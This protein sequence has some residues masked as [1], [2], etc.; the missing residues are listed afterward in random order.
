MFLGHFAIGLGAK[1]IAPAVSLGTLFLAVQF[2]D[3]L[4]PVFVMLGF[5]SFVIQPGI[6]AFTPLDFVHYPY[7]HSLLMSLLWG[8]AFAIVYFFAGRGRKQAAGMLAL[9]VLSHWLLDVASHR[10]DMPL[11]PG[12]DILVGLGLW[13]SVPATVIV[14]GLMFVAGIFLYL[15]TTTATDRIGVYAFWG[16]IAFLVL[17]NLGNIFGPPPPG[18]EAVTRSALAIWL[19]IA[20]GYWI[21]RHRTLRTTA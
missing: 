16:L 11:M 20:W 17:I 6:T 4:W 15:Q 13:N 19:L 14:E 9:L 18:V 8:L 5:E 7:S 3:L 12:S 10:P 21:D 2:A 1:R